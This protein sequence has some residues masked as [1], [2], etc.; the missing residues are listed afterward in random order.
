[1]TSRW[2]VK[3]ALK[4]AVEWS[5]EISGGGWAYRRTASFRE[6]F[7]IL[8]YHK[9]ANEP[10]NSFTVKTEHFRAHMRYLSDHCNVM[11]M[12]ELADLLARGGRPEEGSVAVTFDDG[13]REAAY[14]VA[15]TL[16]GCGIPATFFVVTGVLDKAVNLPNGPYLTWREVKR[17]ADAGFSIGSHTV[18]HPSLG[19][20]DPASVRKE[21]T[22]SRARITE[23][24][25]SCPD[26]LAYPYGTRRDF[27]HETAQAAAK[28]GYRYAVTAIHGLNRSGDDPFLLRRT[29]V[30]AGDG[31]R[32][33][34]M[35][36]K[37]CLDPWMIVDRWGTRLQR[38]YDW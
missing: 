29:T 2:A 14:E 31:L 16:Q 11:G 4:W 3:R 28:T 15:E 32:T 9:I 34:R 26:G 6:G 19:E 20:L 25:G 17:M 22:I 12:G 35:I 27:S 38:T 37:G 10:Q 18:S 24:V 33:F 13:Y 30:G 5:M 21:L 1:M 36:L 8:T 7:R 23:E